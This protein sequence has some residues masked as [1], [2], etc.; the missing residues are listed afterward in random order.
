MAR[1][2][3]KCLGQTPNFASYPPSDISDLIREAVM[4]FAPPGQTEVHFT[5]GSGSLANE[6]A[7]RAALA[8]YDEIHGG[9]SKGSSNLSVLSFSDNSHSDTLL[10]TCLTFNKENVSSVQE[11]PT[12]ES[13]QTRYPYQ[14]HK[15]FNE[16]HEKNKLEEV[17]HTIDEH[18]ERGSPV[19]AIIV[20]PISFLGNHVATPRYYQKLRNIALENNIPFIVDETRT[21]V[22]KAGRLWAH[23]NWFLE[24]EPDFVTFG[25]SAVASGYFSTPDFRADEES[26]ASV[27]KIIT[28]GKIM[29]YIKRKGLIEK[30]E[31]CG[32]FIKA[33]LGRVSKHYDTFG[34]I[35]GNGTF[36]GWDVKDGNNAAHLQTH[37]IRNGI[38]TAL[39]GPQTIGIR[40][41]L[42][43]RAHH[44][45]HLRDAM[46]RYNPNF[47]FEAS[48]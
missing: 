39:V 12:L 19:G 33:E 28:F 37:L 20:E 31:D 38:I 17:Q 32:N 2:Y 11:W 42:M 16:M 21:G 27:E 5:E 9:A 6:A 1:A 18:K 13:P 26:S 15:H 7:I 48:F 40:P 29:N 46:E 44:A 24:V 45:A 35:R 25:G 3:N 4:P 47:H 41:S 34:N 43:L 22:A 10:S 8:V 30:T 36:I 23:E 14:T